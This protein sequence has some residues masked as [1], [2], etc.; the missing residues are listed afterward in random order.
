VLQ[1]SVLLVDHRSGRRSHLFGAILLRR[2]QTGAV[3]EKIAAVPNGRSSLDSITDEFISQVAG[4]TEIKLSD[5][6]S[7]AV[8]GAIH[9]KISILSGGPGTG[10]TTTL[11]VLVQICKL[12]DC[13][14]LLVSPTGRA[15]KRLASSTGS[16]ASTVHRAL[17]FS[18]EGRG[19]IHNDKNP[20]D[21][22]IVICDEASMLDTHLAVGLLN[23]IKP[24]AH[25]LLV[26]DPDQLPSVGA[27][28][29][30]N[31]L[32]RSNALPITVLKEV[33][34]QAADSAIIGNAASH[35][36][37]KPAEPFECRSL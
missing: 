27:G 28:N 10:K 34:R 25:L 35:L 6:Q 37:C 9:N 4:K 33:R 16:E 21:A 3:V 30:L 17:G 13:K 18:P 2:S 36:L 1:G 11:R 20:L 15:A 26:G 5:S 12:S 23:A 8:T 24:D 29:V 31:D 32:I 19:F 22:D 7:Q 14:V